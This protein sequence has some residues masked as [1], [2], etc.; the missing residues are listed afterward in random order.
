[1]KKKL[2]ALSNL[3]RI[4]LKPSYWVGALRQ[5][6]LTLKKNPSPSEISDDSQSIIIFLPGWTCDA[7][8]YR[9]LTAELQQLGHTVV[10]P[11]TFPSGLRAVF[12][13]KS[14]GE[15]ALLV[16]K[17]LDSIREKL[18]ERKINIVGHSNGG[19]VGLITKMLEERSAV[20]SKI[21]Q[22][23]TLSSPVKPADKI[24]HIPLLSAYYRGVKDLRSGSGAH[25]KFS[26][27]DTRNVTHFVTTRDQLF[28]ADKQFLDPQN[29]VS[30]DHGHF[31]YFS[32]S[33]KQ[34][35][36]TATKIDAVL[37][38]K[39]YNQQREFFGEQVHFFKTKK[40]TSIKI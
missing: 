39:S 23:I 31:D 7:S 33:R 40:N 37:R 19:V 36:E 20:R 6:L 10:S 3:G 2:S 21:D 16:M 24:G 13:R 17:Y 30:G 27:I 18:G 35:A 38:L 26:T 32:G 29:I 28:S 1:M 12:W 9:H 5:L 22:V 11:D 4:M 8:T 14:L 15:Q 34:I 25:E